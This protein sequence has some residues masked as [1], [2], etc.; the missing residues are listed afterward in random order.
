M[1]TPTIVRSDTAITADVIAELTWDPAV[2]V[3]DLDVSTSGGYVTLS[4]TAATFS[5]KDVAE[6]AAYRVLGVRGVTNNIIVD[7]V[8]LGIR[9]DAA[10]EADVRAML[11]LD[12]LVPL[13]RLGVSVSNGIVTLTGNLDYYYQRAAAEDDAGDIAGVLGVVDLITVTPPD[14]VAVDVADSIAQAF[15]RNAELADDNVIVT[16]D[17]AT[18]TLSGTVG[19]WSEYD[20]AVDAAWRAPGVGAVVNNI[21]VTY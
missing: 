11:D 17:G 8:L 4:G 19:T 21:L 9:S 3:A 12:I 6:D 18:V 15:A 10:I 14:M 1:A 7:P 5:I 2:T 13:D 16:V 20:E